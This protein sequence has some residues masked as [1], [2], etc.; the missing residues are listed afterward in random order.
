MALEPVN[1]IRKTPI[2]IGNTRIILSGEKVYVPENKIKP[3][4]PNIITPTINNITS[5]LT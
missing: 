2:P 5:F 1:I 3:G 4:I